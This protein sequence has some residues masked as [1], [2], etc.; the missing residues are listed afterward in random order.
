MTTALPSS[1]VTASPV[2]NGPFDAGP[3]GW[4]RQARPFRGVRITIG[5][6]LLIV[7]L[8]AWAP[9]ALLAALQGHAFSLNPH[10][11]LLQDLEVFA[12][13]LVAAPLFVAASGAYLPQLAATVRTF[14]DAGLIA[15]HD[16]ARYDTLV[17][18]TRRLLTSRLTDVT[19][20]GV[21]YLLTFT[22][23]PALSWEGP[24][25]MISA[26]GHLL[27]AGWWRVLISQPLFLAL[28]SVWL[29][30]LVLW[31]RF[32]WT[33]SRL[34]LRLVAGHPDRLGGLRFALIPLRGFSILAFAFGTVVAGTVAEEVL[35]NGKLPADFTY[36]IG[37]QVVAVLVAF[38]G[39]LLLLSHPL[40]RAKDQGI[41]AYGRL[42]SALGRQFEA[43]WVDAGHRDTT[44]TGLESGE[45][46]AT[47]DMFSIVAN[48]TAVNPLVLDYR[49]VL[50]LATAT[51]LPYVPV[52]LA[53]MPLNRLL[54]L[55]VETLL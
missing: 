42:A 2:D 15:D 41:I 31:I 13:Y 16:R 45:F 40:M 6:R 47:I 28:W 49:H 50:L 48:T 17:A 5:Q 51:L 27:W 8:V 20:V 10:E 11:S 22:A 38:G 9:L 55:T 54:Q 12:R 4:L 36:V 14:V 30:R 35:V 52:M 3:Y 29:W 21:A 33:V 39:P 34:D 46:S 32:L 19:L 53:V 43:H 23:S 24:T 37:A 1:D 18:S 44:T 7:A 26:D 25:W